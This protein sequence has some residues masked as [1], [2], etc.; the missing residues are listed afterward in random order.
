MTQA[1]GTIF[2][3]VAPSGAGKTSLVAA[4]LEA[5]PTVGLS[6]SYTTRKPREGEIDGKHYHF[7]SHAEFES[8]ISRGDFLEYAEVYGNYYGTSRGWIRSQ[9]AEGHDILLEIDWQ[10]ARQVRQAFPEA[11]GIFI[12]PPSIEELERRLRGRATDTPEVIARRLASARQEVDM[13]PEYDYMV[14]N[15]QFER[16]RFDLISIV[17]AQRLRTEVQRVRFADKLAHMGSQR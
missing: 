8:M 13:I 5:E 1:S 11:V 17:R 14:V 3:V 12:V 4:L 7:I 2:I 15:E 6:V 10:G 16:A 9:L